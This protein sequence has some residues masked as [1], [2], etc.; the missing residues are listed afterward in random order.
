MKKDKLQLIAI[1]VKAATAVG[2][3]SLVL[4]NN[5]PYI[6]LTVLVVGAIANEV[7]EWYKKK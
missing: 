7:V 6:A 2:G 5:H 3:G 1:C 4:E